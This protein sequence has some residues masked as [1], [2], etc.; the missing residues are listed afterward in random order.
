MASFLAFVFFFSI[1]VKDIPRETIFIFTA[2]MQ[3]YLKDN[4]K[5]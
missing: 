3:K 4:I 2:L 1:L 5:V